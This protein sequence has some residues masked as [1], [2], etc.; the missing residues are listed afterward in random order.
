MDTVAIVVGLV[1]R[2]ILLPELR[3]ES[4]PVFETFHVTYRVIIVP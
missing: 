3:M 1:K 2:K 4:Y